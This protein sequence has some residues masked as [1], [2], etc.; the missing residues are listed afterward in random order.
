MYVKLSVSVFLCVCVGLHL[1]SD[2]KGIERGFRISF[3][4]K[5]ESWDLNILGPR[6]EKDRVIC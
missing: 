4:S 5:L 3:P 1:L 2:L 6:K